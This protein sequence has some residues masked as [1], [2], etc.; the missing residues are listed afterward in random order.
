[1]IFITALLTLVFGFSAFA[2]QRS[3][4][5]VALQLAPFKQ[6]YDTREEWPK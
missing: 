5:N 2:Q 3:E 4:I 1:M 6:Y